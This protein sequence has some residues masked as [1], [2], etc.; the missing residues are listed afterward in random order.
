[1]L[2]ELLIDAVFKVTQ[3]VYE[4]LHSM[5]IKA[6]EDANRRAP[7]PFHATAG[8][9]STRTK[10]ML[11]HKNPVHCFLPRLRFL[12]LRV[13]FFVGSRPVVCQRGTSHVTICH[14]HA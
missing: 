13:I 11:K 10:V 4:A 3:V 2:P 14:R 5:T 1:M 7:F 12:F 9:L 8:R 6:W